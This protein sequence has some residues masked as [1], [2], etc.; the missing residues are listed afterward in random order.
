MA[1]TPRAERDWITVQAFH[2]Q[3]PHTGSR[4]HLYNLCATGVLRHVRLGG[5]ILIA[6][7]ALELLAETQAA[8]TEQPS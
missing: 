3:H 2:Q 6:S 8:E 1:T 4:N 5:K 7:D